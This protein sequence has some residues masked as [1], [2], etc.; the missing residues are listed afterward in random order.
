MPLDTGR[1]PP[2]LFER[3][4]PM[5]REIAE[6]V[7]SEYGPDELIKR[8]ADPVWFQALSCVIGMDWNSSGTTTITTGALKEAVRGREEDLGVFMCGGKGKASRKTPE[9]IT[10]WGETLSLPDGRSERLVHNSRMSAKVDSSLLQDGYQLY[11]HTFLFTA[12][13]SWTVIQQGMNAENGTARRYH[14][15]SDDVTDLVIEPHVG[16]AR[17]GS[18]LAQLNMTSRYSEDAR[19]LSTEF[20]TGSYRSLLR[21]L[22]L[23]DK[24]SSEL[25]RMKR[26]GTA[27]GQQELTLL[28]VSNTE[29]R[30]HP[31]LQENFS[32]SHYLK[33]IL[34]QLHESEPRTYEQL[35]ATQGVGPKTVRALA[36]VAEII[37]GAAPSY[38]DPARYSFAVGGKDGTP[39]PVDTDAYDK[40]LESLRQ[41]VKKTKLPYS[42]KRRALNALDNTYASV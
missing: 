16:I 30:R 37:Y 6:I 15:F 5:A 12:S 29:F 38:Q 20:F 41:V 17:Q 4:V 35:V 3:M 31:V 26:F 14:W 19:D 21:D 40:T 42:E 24:H 27:D 1:V 9:Q 32:R 34:W 28:D 33:K 10:A 23:L 39:Y 2:W 11:H 7:V 25:S 8:M 13:G 18:A 36:L 22:Q